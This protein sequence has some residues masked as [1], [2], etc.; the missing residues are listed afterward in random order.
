MNDIKRYDNG[1]EYTNSGDIVSDA[2]LII[3]RSQKAAHQA[4]NVALVQRNWLLGM[5]IVED[6]LDGQTRVELYGRRVIPLL[7]NE[8]T[9]AYGKGFTRTSL[10]QCVKFYRYFPEIVQTLS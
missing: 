7:A 1:I 3:E 10:Y 8:L 2:R 9:K 4:I 6:D 5:R